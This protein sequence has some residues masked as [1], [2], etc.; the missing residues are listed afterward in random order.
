MCNVSQNEWM[1]GHYPISWMPL[2]VRMQI[3]NC[4]DGSI[5]SGNCY[6]RFA[7]LLGFD[8]DISNSIHARS[9]GNHLVCGSPTINLLHH[10]AGTIQEVQLALLQMKS[11][12][13]DV[14][15]SNIHLIG[16]NHHVY[17]Q[18]TGNTSIANTEHSHC[19][20]AECIR[21][22]SWNISC[23][24]FSPLSVSSGIASVNPNCKSQSEALLQMNQKLINISYDKNVKKKDVQSDQNTNQ[25][26]KNEQR[27]PCVPPDSEHQMINAHSEGELNVQ[28]NSETKFSL[29]PHS[30]LKTETGSS[31]GSNLQ[32]DEETYC[33]SVFP[34]PVNSC[35]SPH[36][37]ETMAPLHYLSNANKS[38]FQPFS[39]ERIQE[40][41]CFENQMDN[42]SVCQKL[43]GKKS[44]TT[45]ASKSRETNQSSTALPLRHSWHNQHDNLTRNSSL[46]QSSSDSQLS[47]HNLSSAL[48]PERDLT[49]VFNQLTLNSNRPESTGHH[50]QGI[51]QENRNSFNNLG[52]VNTNVQTGPEQLQNQRNNRDRFVFVTYS[53][54]SL[55][56][57]ELFLEE[58]TALCKLFRKFNIRVR[59]DMDPDTYRQLRVNKIHWIEQM[60]NEA[61]FI[62]ACVTPTYAA[63]IQNPSG[64]LATPRVSQLNARYIYDMI[65]REY[66]QNQAQNYRVIPVVFTNFGTKITHVPTCMR[67]TLVYTY[68]DHA[69]QIVRRAL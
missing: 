32:D 69:E 41:H 54:N 3:A 48:V 22:Q 43:A 65:R 64:D 11:S 67:S 60:F 38:N 10:Y 16:R 27:P 45:C 68:P 53:Y 14:I 19:N 7:E 33:K 24:P 29:R 26:T 40:D 37:S 8:F 9:I 47:V 34:S 23:Q 15:P 25:A 17:I 21:R 39:M 49:R 59:T 58:F 13:A 55:V 12:A 1:S 28:K 44:S 35:G 52:H 61:S 42:C 63:D 62:I 51:I 31:F 20:C 46:S 50:I 6:M 4:I 2:C 18:Q 30:S 36:P 57:S 56:D 66:Y 5:S